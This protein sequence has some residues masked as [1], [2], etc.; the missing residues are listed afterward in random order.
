[1]AYVPDW[2]RLA[3]VL[4]RV[5]DAGRAEHEAQHDICNAIAD[6]KIKIRPRVEFLTEGPS[7]AW[8]NHRFA[9]EYRNFLGELFDATDSL[10]VP[11]QLEPGDF[12]WAESRFETPWLFEPGMKGFPGPPRSGYVRIELFSADVSKVLCNGQ[13]SA[14]RTVHDETAAI[15]ALGQHLKNNRDVSREDAFEWCRANGFSLSA[16]GFQNRVWPKAREDA[17]LSPR[18]APGRKPRPG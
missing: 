6:R 18:A 4:A 17:G 14:T 16:R 12:H 2:E 3:D 8:N 1:M 13:S 15:K 7:D 11:S 10:N 9:R 5:I